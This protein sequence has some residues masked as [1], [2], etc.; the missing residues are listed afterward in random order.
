MGSRVNG[1]VAHVAVFREVKV[2]DLRPLQSVPGIRFV[3]ADVMSLGQGFTN[4]ADS[5]SCLHA[6][7]H[8]GPGRYGDP[9]NYDGW[10]MGLAALT[11]MLEV[12]GILYL[13]VPT[14]YEQR[15]EFN[16]HRI[17]S[18]PFLRDT[19]LKDFSIEQC[20]FVNDAGDLIDNV[21]VWGP[22]A[23]RSFGATYGCS[24]WVLRKK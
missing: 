1:F 22:E 14:G 11:R 20:A 5:V 24:I 13:S 10:K 3:Q 4:V 18:L 12:G 6:L 15:V 21:D 7:E 2:L 17:F 8:F 9:V 23:E 16:A 19:L